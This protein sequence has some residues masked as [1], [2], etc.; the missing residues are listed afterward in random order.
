VQA[1]DGKAIVI[2][3]SDAKMPARPALILGS[4]APRDLA[5]E[6]IPSSFPST[7]L[8]TPQQVIFPSGDGMLLHGQLFL[9]PGGA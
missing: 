2:L 3:R 4:S 5:P 7:A 8:V 6:L 9:P 1:S